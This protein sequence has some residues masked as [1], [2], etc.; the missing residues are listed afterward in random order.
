ML[1]ESLRGALDA[2]VDVDERDASALRDETA[3]DRQ[4]DAAGGPRDQG[5][6]SLEPHGRR[7]PHASA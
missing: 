2:A 3:R 5:R 4:P 7:L 6:A 1:A